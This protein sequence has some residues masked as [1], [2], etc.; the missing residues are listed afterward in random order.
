MR[1]EQNLYKKSRKAFH[2]KAKSPKVAHY[3]FCDRHV[4]AKKPETRDEKNAQAALVF[5]RN[6]FGAN[7]QNIDSWKDFFKQ[8]IDDEDYDPFMEDH[9]PYDKIHE[10]T[11]KKLVMS[12]S[13]TRPVRL[14]DSDD[15]SDS[16]LVTGVMTTLTHK[17]GLSEVVSKNSVAAQIVF[18][19]LS[20]GGYK[21]GYVKDLTPDEA[22]ALLDSS[23]RANDSA[24][25][26]KAN[27][28]ASTKVANSPSELA[29]PNHGSQQ[30]ASTQVDPVA[31]FI[32]DTEGEAA[33]K[34]F[35][36]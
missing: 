22:Q 25:A 8:A 6:Y 19:H 32:G 30:G 24:G 3:P 17:D 14:L 23:P 5:A 29:Q 4:Q 12:F 1:R 26:S 20:S 31:K 11:D 7:Y 21:V 28:S 27:S 36:F 16:F 10:I 35:G 2:L 34:A 18:N 33:K 13:P 9:F 15:S